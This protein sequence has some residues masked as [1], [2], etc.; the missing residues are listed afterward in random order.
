M[1]FGRANFLPLRPRTEL[2]DA[3]ITALNA[4]HLGE[5]T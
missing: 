1:E 2:I 4:A 3:D 5:F